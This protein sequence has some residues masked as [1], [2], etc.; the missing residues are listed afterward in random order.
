MRVSYLHMLGGSARHW[1]EVITAIGPEHQHHPL[2]L[3]GFGDASPVAM[4]V[5]GMAR[6]VADAVLAGPPWIIVG[7]SMGAKVAAV[8]ARWAQDGDP[9]LTQLAGV[10]TL[11]G[12]P[13][14]PEP[15][16]E[17]RRQAMLGW[18]SCGPVGYAH[19]GYFIDQ[20]T[21]SNLRG[22]RRD[23][24][25]SDVERCSPAAWTA[26]L[27]S[28]SQEDWSGR[29]G[30][31]TL[32]ALIVAGAMDEDLG[33]DAQA[34]LMQPHF[35]RAHLAMV[36][37]AKHIL[38]M[39]QPAAVAT[40]I[41][42]FLARLAVPA[43]YMALIDS[44]RVS[45]ATR[46][47]LLSRLDPPPP[48]PLTT[49][50]R[51]TLRA[52]LNRVIPQ[53]DDIDLTARVEA[54]LRTGD[55][56]RPAVLPSDLDACRAGLGALADFVQLDEVAQDAVLTS[57]G[58]RAIWPNGWTSDQMQAWFDDVRDAAV[59]AWVA[60]PATMANLRYSGIAYAG[61]DAFKPG[62]ADPGLGGR[63]AWEP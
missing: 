40:L 8:L 30:A 41:T 50:E 42:G 36:P 48:G 49:A 38:P 6:A 2:D 10:V 7:H 4:D 24:A 26:W 60:H 31:I 27:A 39:E 57:I 9:A 61:D 43:G 18:A 12:S 56:W 25:R 14:G 52:L 55:G 54:G 15:I 22:T 63:E 23:L 32:P 29:V 35:P 47:A 20:N 53:S 58:N 3:P 51:A 59:R 45:T 5:A 33:A 37:D 46:A 44:P 1:D 21:A 28:G 34:R 19:A 17:R 11:A 62:F 16:E 13:P